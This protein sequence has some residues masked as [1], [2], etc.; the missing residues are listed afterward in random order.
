MAEHLEYEDEIMSSEN[1]EL[2]KCCKLDIIFEDFSTTPFNSPTSSPERNL[3]RSPLFILRE[4]PK[5]FYSRK[6]NLN[7]KKSSDSILETSELDYNIIE[8]KHIHNV[9]E[10]ING[11]VV[12]TG[13]ETGINENYNW[14]EDDNNLFLSISTQEILDQND[15]PSTFKKG[16]QFPANKEITQGNQRSNVALGEG[17]Q[18]LNDFDEVTNKMHRNEE[19]NNAVISLV[20]AGFETANGKK[21]SISEEGL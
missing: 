8:K 9:S 19:V 3:E 15:F 5:R 17:L 4:K 2:I 16:H 18:E 20:S 11:G 21:I 6:K 12:E 7:S 14:D 13:G 1:E 10:G